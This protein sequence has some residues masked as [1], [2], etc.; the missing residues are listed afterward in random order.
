MKNIS[1]L[2]IF[3]FIVN[4][5]ISQ[6]CKKFDRH[7]DGMY[8]WSKAEAKRTLEKT[9]YWNDIESGDVIAD[10]GAYCGHIDLALSM[11]K[12]GLT[13]YLQETQADRLNQ[14]GFYELKDYY[15]KINEKPITNQF[16]FIV[17]DNYHS[18][19]PDSTFD[20]IMFNNVFEY[21]SRYDLYLKDLR[22]KLK[23]NGKVYVQTDNPFD[24]TYFIKIFEANGFTCEKSELKKDFKR[25]VFNTKAKKN[26]VINDIF[27]A[28]IQKDFDKTKQF[29]DNGISVNSTLGV[30]L[31]QIAGSISNNQKIFKL[32]IDKGANLNFDNF[33]VSTPL[34]KFAAAG[35]YELVK[36][37]L[38]N[39]AKP[40]QDALMMSVWFAHDV[41][42]VKLLVD[43]GGPVYNNSENSKYILLF[44][45]KGGDLETIKYILSLPGN[46]NDK[47]NDLGE[48]FIHLAAYGYNIEVM[49][50]LLDEKES[51]LTE[52]NNWGMTVLMYAVFGGSIKTIKYLVSEKK[53]ECE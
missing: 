29:L 49:K 45:A 21:I 16:H 46:S 41:R 20:K 24:T 31:L 36:M 5:G 34:A 1:S 32:L 23:R 22:N 6:Q 38:E 51:N 30:C 52:K 10:I 7:F 40:T 43:Y 44:L 25:L 4:V 3:I 14:N 11:F 17:G 50:Y 28:V 26:I 8:Y 53:N 27:D 37:M 15:S 9:Q 42:I 13:F 48:N 19:L 35:E 18:N 33:F 47:K 2:L 12:E 39:G